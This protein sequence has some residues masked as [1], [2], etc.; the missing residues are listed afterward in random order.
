MSRRIGEAL[1]AKGLLEE[2]QLAEALQLQLISGGHLGTSL[3]D[4]GYVDE[5]RLGETLAELLR[6]RYASREMLRDLPPSAVE[7]LP[8]SLAEKYQAVPLRLEERTLHLAV[9]NPKDLSALSSMTGY[10]IV[11]WVAP[12]VRMF[13]ALETYYGIARRPRYVRL[14]Q[15]L[16]G[17]VERSQRELV[18]ATARRAS[19]STA[20]EHPRAEPQ[21]IEELLGD[22]YGKNWR[23]V[24]RELG[25]LDERLGPE[26]GSSEAGVEP[27]HAEPSV[28]PAPARRLADVLDRMC[29]ADHK[30]ELSEAVLDYVSPG[31]PTCLMLT[32]R[33][34]LA[35]IWDSRGLK[36][37]TE[38]A[39]TLSWPVTS[40][41]IFTLLLGNAH[42]RGPVPEDSGCRLFFET[43]G[44]QVPA[45]VLLYPIYLNDRLVA[46]FYGDSGAKDKIEGETAGYLLVGEKLSMALNLLI[47]KMKLRAV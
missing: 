6:V 42:Y 40:G 18:A 37:S 13:E 20:A 11:P 28:R 44:R 23:V 31:M 8:Q 26:T 10:K 33:S 22:D 34:Q 45:E 3:I 16:D 5:E 14:C 38:R 12:E 35:R 41:S 46:I 36:L 47:L 2:G 29:R 30:E 15:E 17:K 39:R 21:G 27:G 19:A 7:L 25:K 1:V 24:A 32:V 43:L 9:V 4:L